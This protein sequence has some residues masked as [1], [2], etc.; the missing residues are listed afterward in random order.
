[1]IVEADKP[2]SARRAPRMSLGVP[3]DRGPGSFPSLPGLKWI[4][5]TAPVPARLE[6][7]R[8]GHGGWTR[9][10]VLCTSTST[11]RHEY[12]VLVPHLV[13]HHNRNAVRLRRYSLPL[14]LQVQGG[15]GPGTG[16]QQ[17]EHAG[18]RR[19][20]KVRSP[21]ASD[22]LSWVPGRPARSTGKPRWSAINV[23]IG[24]H[25]VGTN[26]L[27]GLMVRGT[28]TPYF[29]TCFEYIENIR[30][31]IHEPAIGKALQ[32][33]QMIGVLL[34]VLVVRVPSTTR[35]VSMVP[36]CTEPL[37]G[38]REGARITI[39]DLTRQSRRRTCEY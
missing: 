33:R 2:E 12:S 10:G 17:L 20:I 27:S 13:P 7:M 9:R 14:S 3:P 23:K 34:L 22:S 25:S 15:G 5:R 21:P 18:S 35:E 4:P 32:S 19:R 8:R 28:S 29:R 30:D 24:S 6:S 11:E 31:N 36:G 26:F 37:Q 38:R 39:H 16:W 1:M